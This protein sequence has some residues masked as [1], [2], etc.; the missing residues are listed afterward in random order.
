MARVTAVRLRERARLAMLGAGG[1]GFVRF[2]PAGGA[3]LATDAIRR[4]GDDA[5]RARLTD[6]MVAAGFVCAARGGLLELTPVDDVLSALGGE[7]TI[8]VDWESPLH[9]AQALARRFLANEQ[10]PLTRAGRQLILETLRLTWL[11]PGKALS[12]LSALRAQAAVMQRRGDRSGLHEAGAV[13]KEY[14]E[15]ERGGRTDEAGMDRTRVF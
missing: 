15:Q 13:L 4:C 6:A 11:E 12:G 8:A 10:R 9:P 2:L 7:E 1:R 5:A 3:L 14:C